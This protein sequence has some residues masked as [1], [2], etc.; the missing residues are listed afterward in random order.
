VTDGASR[1]GIAWIWVALTGI[2]I[3]ALLFAPDIDY[4]RGELHLTTYS[5]GPHGA[6]GLF[7]TVQRLGWPAERRLTP[8]R[9]TLPANAT[10]LILSPPIPP[11]S[12]ETG[13]ILDAVRRGARL[14]VIPS[15]GTALADSLGM[16]VGSGYAFDGMTSLADGAPETLS[17]DV[18]M[19]HWLEPAG[20]DTTEISGGF[21]ELLLVRPRRGQL[22]PA[23]GSI[24]VGSGRI[25]LIADPSFLANGELRQGDAALLAVRLLEWLEVGAGRTTLVFTEW[26]HGR[27]VHPSAMA[28]LTEA[29]FHT[30]PGR[31]LL[32]LLL[33]G[34][35]LLI[36]MG[37][38]PIAP[39]PIGRIERRSPFEHVDALSRA[40]E[41]IEATKIATR[42]L[43]RGVIRRR[44]AGTGPV[45][46]EQDFLNGVQER[47]PHLAPHVQLLVR[48]LDTKLP[49]ADFVRIGEA[50]HTIERTLTQ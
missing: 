17:H 3:L 25:V 20:E 31:A 48:A 16:V 30:A 27:G 9:D 6:R 45:R 22:R 13:M 37:A 14:V 40:Y 24:G 2:I 19:R 49:P 18:R 36:A 10:Y 7:E 39:E 4:G 42:H 32:V 1:R 33:A 8:V 5:A 12:R 35:C 43:V 29:I 15:R 41:Q 11:S 21:E 44:S 50:V 46:R 34:G 26:H 23:V 28:V 38:R 47:H